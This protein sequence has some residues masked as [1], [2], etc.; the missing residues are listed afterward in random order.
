MVNAE[1]LIGP[2]VPEDLSYW[3][4]N[5]KFDGDWV[6]VGIPDTHTNENQPAGYVLAHGDKTFVLQ[7]L[8]SR[9]DKR[10]KILDILELMRLQQNH[11]PAE[12]IGL[13]NLL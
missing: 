1:R 7:D 8:S 5:K 9:E 3:K 6:L 10:I 11:V 13:N 2:E 12:L 4:I